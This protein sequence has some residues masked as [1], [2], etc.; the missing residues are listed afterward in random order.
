MIMMIFLNVLF[1][2]SDVDDNDDIDNDLL[3]FKEKIV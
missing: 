3:Y 1:L 2:L